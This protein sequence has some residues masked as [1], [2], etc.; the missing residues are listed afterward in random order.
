MKPLIA[1]LLTSL[2][3]VAAVGAGSAP[4]VS[5][6]TPPPVTVHVAGNHLV[7]GT[8]APLRLRGVDRQGSEYACVQGWGMFDGPTDDASIALMKSWKI[9]V[10][11]LPLN[12][13][14]WLNINQVPAG[15]G[16]L[17]YR[18]AVA[19][20]VRRLHTA[21]M[22]VVLDLHWNGAGTTQAR[23]QQ[24]MADADHAPAFWRSVAWRFRADPGVVFDLYNEPHDID[25]ACWRDGC[26]ARDATQV[27]GMQALVDKVR[28]TGAKQPIMLSGMNWGGDLSQWLTYAPH[29]PAGQLIA[30][31]HLYNFSG[32]NTE[33]CWDATVAP[34]ARAVPVVTS[35]LGE[36]DCGSS[37]I[38]RYMDWADAH[39]VGYLAWSWGP[40]GCGG[41]GLLNAWDGTPSAM[42]QA[43]R[44]RL[45]G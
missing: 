27:V 37:F 3:T 6:A 8:G 13:D 11:R 41:P 28:S 32:C 25:W 22:A 12:E 39:Q 5:A 10:V 44:D 4:A 30:G 26:T 16:G 43:F 19:D 18:A 24:Q 23:G 9:N 36:T 38:T 2:L 1:T 33:S 15:F 7:D 20:Y 40:W 31:A 14:C 34:V 45:R 17:P 35:E 21:G 42:G 29:D